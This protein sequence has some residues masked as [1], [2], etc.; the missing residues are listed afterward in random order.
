MLTRIQS[1]SRRRLGFTLIELLVVIAIIAILIGLLLPAVQ[2]VR[3]A[4]ARAKCQNNMKQI[5]LAMHN[6]EGVFNSLPPASVQAANGGPYPQLA[7]FLKVGTTGALG[8]DYARHSFLSIMLPYIEAANVL[9]QGAGGYNY[10]LDWDN[11]QNRPAASTRIPT[12]ECPSATNDHTV[13]PTLAGIGWSPRTTDYF[14]TTR[15]NGIPNA[16]INVGLQFPGGGTGTTANNAAVLGILVNAQRTPFAAVTDGLSNTFMIAEDG[17]R[18]EGWAY[19]KQYTPQ[20]T[21]VNGAWAASG[22]DIVCAG[23]VAPATAGTQPAKLGAGNVAQATQA[24][25]VNCWNQGEIYAFHTG[26]ANV[27]MGDGSVKTVRSTLSM[28]ALFRLAARSDGNPVSVD[29]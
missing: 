29:D 27:V 22:S 3:E 14:A 16:W 1:R 9:T 5:G 15:A 4:A 25:S 11:T 24:C 28:S 26:V 23:T 2:K 18:P 20:P 7:E 6:Y 21:F 10:R 17:A 8:A 12:Y 19:G 13:P